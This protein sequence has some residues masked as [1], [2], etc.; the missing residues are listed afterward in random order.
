MKASEVRKLSSSELEA[1][2]VELKKDLF[3]LRMQHAT[4]QLDN[5][6]QISL[7]KKDIARVETIIREKQLE[8]GRR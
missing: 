8:A 6:V 5:P 3:F 2:L 1:K 7:V 4:N